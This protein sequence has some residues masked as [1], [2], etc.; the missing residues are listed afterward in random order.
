MAEHTMPVSLV[1]GAS[2]GLGRA[3]A[4]ALAGRGDHVIAC[5]R[6]VGALEALRDAV[7]A[8]GGHISL[9]AFDLADMVALQDCLGQVR[10]RWGR[11][12]VLVHAAAHASPLSPV[13]HGEPTEL[14]RALEINVLATSRLIDG[15]APL[16]GPSGTAVF[17]AD[18]VDGQRFWSVYGS[19]KAAQIA[20]VRSWQAET[21]RSGPRV[22]IFSPRP[23]NTMLRARFFPGED[24]HAL[25]SPDD[26][27]A[28]LV[29]DL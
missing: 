20:L 27:A 11:I 15:A 28:R 18:A 23:M 6:T 3:V 16:L 7:H 24:R 2:R 14:A 19:S 25:A 12:D 29:G 22:M 13:A 5:G 10:E 4:V 21:S 8:A 17:C 9:A 26:E 1:T